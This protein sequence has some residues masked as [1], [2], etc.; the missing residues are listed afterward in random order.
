MT[1]LLNQMV[2]NGVHLAS[3]DIVM[4]ILRSLTDKFDSKKYVIEERNDLKKLTP[5]ELALKLKVFGTGF[6]S[7]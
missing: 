2:S 4:K 3:A 6:E 7:K 5:Q 1:G